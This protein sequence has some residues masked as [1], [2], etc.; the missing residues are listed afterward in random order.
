MIIKSKYEWIMRLKFVEG[1]SQTTCPE[2]VEVQA[3]A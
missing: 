2:K 1:V 3:K